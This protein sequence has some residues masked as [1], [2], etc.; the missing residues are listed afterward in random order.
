M[1]MSLQ[2]NIHKGLNICMCYSVIVMM[3]RFVVLLT[4]TVALAECRVSVRRTHK[5]YHINNNVLIYSELNGYYYC[6]N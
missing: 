3:L 6:A 1:C 2:C 4:L 5:L